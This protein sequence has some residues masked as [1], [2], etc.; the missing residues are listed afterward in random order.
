MRTALLT[1][2]VC[3]ALLINGCNESKSDASADLS[4]QERKLID[5]QVALINLLPTSIAESCETLQRLAR[6]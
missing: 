5:G 1:T 2:V 3:L 4:E 6:V